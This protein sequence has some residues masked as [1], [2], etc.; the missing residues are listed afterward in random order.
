MIGGAFQEGSNLVLAPSKWAWVPSSVSS[1][2]VPP[3][4]SQY[5]HPSGVQQ[6]SQVLDETLYTE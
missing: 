5:H 3:L 6:D 4:L 1:V 2:T